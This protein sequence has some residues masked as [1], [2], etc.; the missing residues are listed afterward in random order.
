MQIKE[1]PQSDTLSNLFI[2]SKKV[3]DGIKQDIKYDH[4]MNYS[5]VYD[6]PKYY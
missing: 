3:D 1:A 2:R 5:K 4:K 6:N